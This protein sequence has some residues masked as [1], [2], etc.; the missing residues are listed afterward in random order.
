MQTLSVNGIQRQSPVSTAANEPRLLPTA[1]PT[2]TQAPLDLLFCPS[3][4][5]IELPPHDRSDGCE[6][7]AIA[8]GGAEEVDHDAAGAAV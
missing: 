5:F 3:F 8:A 4:W 1:T 7:A 6:T 2:P